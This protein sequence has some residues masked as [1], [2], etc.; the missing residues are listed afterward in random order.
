MKKA[1]TK[2]KQTRRK[3]TPKR[4]IEAPLPMVLKAIAE[5]YPGDASA[6]GLVLSF[7]PS[8]LFYASIC[9]YEQ[10]MG[11]G[12]KVICSYQA[13]TPEGAI[14]GCAE[15][16]LNGTQN[17]RRLRRAIPN[18]CDLPDEIDFDWEAGDRG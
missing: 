4:K 3:A 17:A 1:T 18:P 15:A 10:A 9:R 6:P 11:Q 14:A 2:K 13:T 8:K 7:L 12:K 5:L 16:W